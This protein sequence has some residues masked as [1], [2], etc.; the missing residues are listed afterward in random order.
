MKILNQEAKKQIDVLAK[1]ILAK[2]SADKPDFR[3]IAST[4]DVD[5]D[6]EIIKIDAWEIDNYKKNPIILCCH[7]YFDISDV[8][9]KATKIEVQGKKLI[10]EWVFAK[11]NPKAQLLKGLYDEGII[12]T[13]SVGFIP[14]E[15]QGNVITKAELLELSF[16]PVPANPNALADEIKSVAKKLGLEKQAEEL[17]PTD[18]S[19][20]KELAEI[21]SEIK[22]IKSFIKSLADGKADKKTYEV[23][24]ILQTINRV[25]A[26][27]LRDIKSKKI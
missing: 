25:S 9:G 22:E 15:R 14:L 6:G 13:V 1:D 8:M 19:I 20:E 12:K 26:E 2:L 5:R 10:I 4:E 11:S 7:K 21:K 3:V 24:E 23:K 18:S 16:V 27:A 17:L